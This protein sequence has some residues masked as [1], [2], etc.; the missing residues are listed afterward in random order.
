MDPYDYYLAPRFA[1]PEAAHGDPYQPYHPLT[2]P[3]NYRVPTGSYYY[4]QPPRAAFP[5]A[6]NPWG[7]RYVEAGGD[8]GGAFDSSA[9]RWY[10]PA[11]ADGGG[12]SV[13]V[14]GVDDSWWHPFTSW[15]FH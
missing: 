5:S 12:V 4:T 13:P 15:L 11:Y 8:Y 1:P 3:R 7:S 9:A 14:G 2:D 6:S 10:V